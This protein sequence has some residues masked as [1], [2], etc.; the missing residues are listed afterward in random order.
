MA[1]HLLSGGRRQEKSESKDSPMG[2]EFFIARRYLRAKRGNIF[3]AIVTAISVAGVAVG[4]ACV[5]V[6][7]SIANGFRVDLRDKILGTNAHV[8]V[9]RYHNEPISGYRDLLPSLAEVPHVVGVSPFIYAKAMVSHGNYVDGIVMRGI[10]PG[11]VGSVSNI[12]EYMTAGSIDF[13]EGSPPGVVLGV[14]L[15]SSLRAHLGDVVTLASPFGATATPFGQ[16]PKLEKFRVTGIFDSGMFEYNTSLVYVSL[17][18]A[19][20]FL[21]LGD[22]VTGIELRLDDIYQAPDVAEIV[23]AELRYPYRTN[24]WIELNRNLFSALKLEKTTMFIV[25]TLIIIVAAFNIISTLIMIVMKKTKEIGI[26]KSMGSTRQSVMKIFILE[27]LIIGILGTAAGA[28]L[29]FVLCWL[30]G[31]YHFISLPSEVY[32]ISTLPVSMEPADFILVSL[33]AI[34]ITFLATIY[35]ARK[36][37]SLAPVEAIR[38]E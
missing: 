27:G 5:T 30:L 29:G 37:A 12:A 33:A 17:E 9:L 3:Q 18:A 36:G 1:S 32:F 13:G 15:A 11:S 21:G 14:D 4:V 22:R 10:D 16:I 34:V 20:R 28:S 35:P 23:E 19:Q 8:H 26:L 2:Y 6:V 25:L 38:Y 24:H 7:L 31:K